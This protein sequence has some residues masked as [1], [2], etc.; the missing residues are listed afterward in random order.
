MY[1][2]CILSLVRFFLDGSAGSVLIT[3]SVQSATMVTNIILDTGEQETT[4]NPDH[5]VKISAVLSEILNHL[6]NK[7]RRS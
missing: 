6:N 1:S 2:T 5:V 3:I 4:G 7:S